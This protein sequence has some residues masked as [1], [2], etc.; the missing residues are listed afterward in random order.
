MTPT[1]NYYVNQKIQQYFNEMKLPQTE[2]KLLA[3]HVVSA[4]R[5]KGAI[6]ANQS[7]EN[8]S[9]FVYPFRKK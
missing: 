4:L 1:I 2:Q 5:K 6:Q 7:S 3:E 9:V 8:D